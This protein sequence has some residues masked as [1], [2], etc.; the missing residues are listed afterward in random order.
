MLKI[1]GLNVQH[2]SLKLILIYLL[3]SSW[4]EKKQKAWVAEAL[5]LN[6]MIIAWKDSH[7]EDVMAHQEAFTDNDIIAP[8]RTTNQL[9]WKAKMRS[10][11]QNEDVYIFVCIHL[12]FIEIN[13]P[14]S[15]LSWGNIASLTHRLLGKSSH[16]GFGGSWNYHHYAMWLWSGL[17]W[18]LQS[19]S[20]FSLS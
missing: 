3:L 2:S 18:P 1:A 16:V 13:W 15:T 14:Y 6:K 20:W 4:S 12:Q 10:A 9:K 19:H 7:M 17:K 11:A 8:L 5:H